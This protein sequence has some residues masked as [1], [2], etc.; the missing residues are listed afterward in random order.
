MKLKKISFEYD[1]EADVLYV[2]FGKPKKAIV[3]EKKNMGIRIDE[4]TGEIVGCTIMNFL[5]T[6]AKSQKPLTVSVLK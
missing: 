5:E 6:M 1:K 2:S 4:K 3:E